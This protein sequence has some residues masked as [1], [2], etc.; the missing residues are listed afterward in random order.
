[1][2]YFTK[3]PEDIQTHIYQLSYTQS[4]MNVL[5]NLTRSVQHELLY[6]GDPKVDEPVTTLKIRHLDLEATYSYTQT[7]SDNG[8]MYLTLGC[9]SRSPKVISEKLFRQHSKYNK[10]VPEIFERAGIHLD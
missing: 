3:L 9:W 2:N 8:E 10:I 6:F 7:G 4:Y 1:M 5:D